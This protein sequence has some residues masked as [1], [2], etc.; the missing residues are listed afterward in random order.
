VLQV[1]SAEVN[2]SLWHVVF[3]NEDVEEKRRKALQER[4]LMRERNIEAS[5]HIWEKEI[6]P[7]WSVVHRD[8]TLRKLWWKGVPTQLRAS[9][10][11]KAVGNALAIS[12]GDI[13]ISGA[14]IIFVDNSRADNYRACLARAKRA[15]GNGTFPVATLANI[16][17]DILSTLPVLHIF[18]PETGPM[19]QDL[20]DILCA[21]VVARQDEALGYKMGIAR[22]AAMFIINMPPQQAFVVMRNLLER[23]CLRSF[24]GGI[25]TKDDVS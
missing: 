1:S 7:D 13:A 19:Y 9:M 5:L 24:Y 25:S 2:Q 11:E 22:I 3:I 8:P 21:W 4:R 16:E 14:K 20:K 12:K 23:H 17:E 10:W 15:L 6:V 18:H